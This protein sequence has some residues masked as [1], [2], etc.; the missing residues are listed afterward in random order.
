MPV[1]V[2][3]YGRIVG[4]LR[5]VR[6]NIY[7]YI[8][9]YIHTYM[10]V[11]VYIYIYIYTH[12]YTYSGPE[13]DNRRTKVLLS[14]WIPF[15]DHPSNLERCRSRFSKGGVQWKQGVAMYMMLCP[16]LL[17]NTTPIHCTPLRLH[18]PDRQLASSACS[19]A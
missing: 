10:C 1:S 3:V 5:K 11:Y 12:T 13:D 18:P 7:I 9:I 14:T 17:Y 6:G 2:I 19:L 16:S 15:G 4:S 8:Y